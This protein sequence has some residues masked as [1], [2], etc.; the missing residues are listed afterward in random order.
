MNDE[1]PVIWVSEDEIRRT[2]NGLGWFALVEEGTYTAVLKRNSHL[3]S[4]PEGEPFCTH[5][6]IAYYYDTSGQPIAIVHQYRRPDGHLG[7]SGLP[8]PKRLFL[9]DRIIAVRSSPST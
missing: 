3:S 6:Q 8:D 2:F 9:S 1:R 7:A 5:S 4:P